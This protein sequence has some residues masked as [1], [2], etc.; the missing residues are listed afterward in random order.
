MIILRLRVQKLKNTTPA[1][2]NQAN[3]PQKPPKI[4]ADLIPL[5]R[6]NPFLKKSVNP[7]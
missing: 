5:I 4:K 3:F 6:I 1:N 7:V 2:E